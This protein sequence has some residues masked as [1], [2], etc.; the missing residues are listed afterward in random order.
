LEKLILD[1]NFIANEGVNAFSDA[2]G[3]YSR[4]TELALTNNRGNSGVTATGLVAISSVLH[5]PHS[6]SSKLCLSGNPINDKVMISFAEALV[7]TNLLKELI[8]D[9]YLS[10]ITADGCTD[11]THLLCKNSSTMHK[12]CHDES[13]LPKNLK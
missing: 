13:L 8:F 7:N 9:D 3:I 11:V 1:N 6:A 4:L 12:F 10:C 5:N 2:L